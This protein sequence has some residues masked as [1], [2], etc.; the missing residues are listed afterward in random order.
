MDA[1]LKLQAAEAGLANLRV[2]LQNDLLTTRAAAAQHRSRLQQGEDAGAD[3][4]S[5]RQ[6]SA[7][8]GP[9]AEAVAGRCRLARR[10]ATR[11]RRISSRRKAD[12]TRAQLAVQQ[13]AVDQARAVLQLKQ[14]QKDELKVR[15][16]IDG[17]LQLVPVEVGQQVAPGHEPGARREPD[18][19]EGGNQDRGNAGQGH[20]D[21]PEGRSRHAQRHRPGQRRAHRSVGASTARARSTCRCPTNCR[22]APSPI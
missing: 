12:S 22:R 19:P 9:R 6:G 10:R 5:A 8:V 3:E 2:Q 17:M 1:Q 7:R 4:R 18:P 13:S 14:Q 11:S 15:A 20:P 16:G 21:R